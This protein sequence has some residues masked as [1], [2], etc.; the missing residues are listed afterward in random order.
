MA[1]VAAETPD[2]RPLRIGEILD[3][4]IKVYTRNAGT[5]FR[6][7]AIIIIPVQ[8][9]GV[10]IILSTFP[11]SLADA[12][13]NPFIPDPNAPVP[14]ID[15]REI[16]IFFTAAMLVNILNFIGVTLATGACFKAV[17]DAY[18]GARSD[19]RTSMR[20]ALR[21]LRS[22]LWI[23][24]LVALSSGLGLI[25][26]IAPGV[27]MWAAFAVATP[28]LLTEG[29]KGTKAIG[30]SVNLVQ[31]RWWNTFA[32]LL[33]AFALAFILSSILGGLISALTFIDVGQNFVLVQSLNAVA[34]ALASI[35]ATPF[36]AAVVAV[37]YFDLRVRK[38]GFDLQLLAQRMGT[39][40][41][42]GARAALLPPPLPPALYGTPGAPPP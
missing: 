35:I 37:L 22:L 41:P 3:V 13:A 32:V 24:F 10:F 27:W 9:V 28:V 1:T 33:V 42:D 31:K 18:L 29:I 12:S 21:H 25:L 8:I 2:L 5:L 30:R 17:T 20:F 4:A 19:W 40:T 38:E 6:I 23:T 16:G 34:T 11:D 15:F 7:V 39:E 36:Q 26:C 14:E